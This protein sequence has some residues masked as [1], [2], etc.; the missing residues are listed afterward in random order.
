MR[1]VPR[2]G[3]LLLA[4]V[5]AAPL[6]LAGCGDQDQPERAREA[7]P[8]PTA[9]ATATGAGSPSAASPGVAG[10]PRATVTV[11]VP[12]GLRRAPFDVP[13]RLT[14]PAGWA[15]SVYARVAKARF[16]AV[17][18]GG[19][20]LVSQPSTGA[21]LLVRR[22][23]GGAGRVSPFLRGLNRPHDIVFAEVGGRSFVFVAEADRVVRYP[24][25]AGDSTARPGQPVVTGL[26]DT[27]TPE[28]RG[29]YSHVLK[30]I[31]VRG[32]VLYVSIASTCN[33]CVSDTRSDPQRAAIYTYDAAGTNAGRRL[34]ARGL[35]NAE[36][37]AFVPGTGD[38]WAVV[39]NRDNTLVPDDRDVDG[40]GRGD[41]GRRMTEFVD[42]YPVEPFTRVVRSGFYGWPFCNPN[43]D[44]GVRRM[45]YH[46][47]YQ[48]NRDGRAADCATA[49]PIDVGLPAHTAPLGLTFTQGTPAPDLGAVIALHGSWNRST[50]SG[51]KV[52]HFPWTAAGPGNQYDLATGWLDAGT[53]RSWG[54]PVDVAVDT[55]GSLLVSDDAAG[56][57][58][59][60]VPRR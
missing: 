28:L 22:A 21:V 15:A 27:S 36:G 3:R 54:R 56:A 41:R 59:R 17:A 26:P 40:D 6:A 55:D 5:L 16:L 31:A 52:I 7:T 49:T 45:G 30:N 50:P 9:S 32:N 12:A 44:R 37:L 33:A 4:A 53:G 51:Y 24:Y 47:D 13:R 34:Y 14:L 25:Q 57:V 29:Q 10:G 42:D 2:S 11:G 35:R 20:L 23:G 43:S 46:R 38:L 60:L 58:L 1:W 8:A 19:D 39:N 48:L 18:P